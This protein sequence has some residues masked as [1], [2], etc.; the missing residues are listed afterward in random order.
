[1]NEIL[2]NNNTEE[3]YVFE[4]MMY[5]EELIEEFGILHPLIDKTTK[6]LGD[7]IKE[8]VDRGWCFSENFSIGLTRYLDRWIAR[9]D[10][11]I[12]EQQRLADEKS[13]GSLLS[14]LFGCIFIFGIGAFLYRVF[15]KNDPA[16]VLHHHSGSVTDNININ[17]SGYVTENINL[18]LS[19]F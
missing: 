4:T 10:K 16:Q 18:K 13:N 14:A 3:K 12:E 2:S 8:S 9:R 19:K 5:I 17:H 15:Q 6:G 1:M 11:A 7:Y